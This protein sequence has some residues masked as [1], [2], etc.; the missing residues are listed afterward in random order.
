MIAHPVEISVGCRPDVP[1]AS[2]MVTAP[3]PGGF[4]HRVYQFEVV[5]LVDTCAETLE[6]ETWPLVPAVTYPALALV[7]SSTAR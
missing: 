2:V 7:R 4:A 6:S 1:W 5:V 3:L